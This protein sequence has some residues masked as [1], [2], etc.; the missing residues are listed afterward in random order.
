MNTRTTAPYNDGV[1][2]WQAIFP[3]MEVLEPGHS[4]T[5][6]SYR[7]AEVDWSADEIW[8]WWNSMRPI[9]S[10]RLAIDDD[11]MPKERATIPP[12]LSE[13]EWPGSWWREEGRQYTRRHEYPRSIGHS[14]P[15]NTQDL[16]V[17]STVAHRAVRT[18]SRRPAN[19]DEVLMDLA[20]ISQEAGEEGI[21]VPSL[22]LLEEGRQYARRYE[23]P[24]S[25]GY[26]VPLN[27][28][29]LPVPSTAAQRVV[30][31]PS[32]RPTKLD[33]A[34][35]DLALISQEAEEEGIPVPSPQL[36]KVAEQ[37]LEA[38]YAVDQRRYSVYSTLDG[39]IELD[40]QAP[41][42]SKIVVTCDANGTARCIVYEEGAF[43]IQKYENPFEIPDAFVRAALGRIPV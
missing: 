31:T 39:H 3:H 4:S 11:Q 13:E 30:Q 33:E 37:V 41:F 43:E 38:L 34:L 40:A 1:A 35:M 14:V 25:I 32:R 9:S 20:M 28:Q 22:Q 17:P 23:Y 10:T 24:R 12:Q 29:D 21:P 36:L 16:S 7:I 19:L 15:L 2:Y 26:F 8:T 6:Q 42:G 18:P 5:V 27:R